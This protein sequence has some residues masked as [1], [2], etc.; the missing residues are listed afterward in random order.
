[1]ERAAIMQGDGW[2]LKIDHPAGRLS[3]GAVHHRK[4][5]YMEQQTDGRQG[6]ATPT[7]FFV[8]LTPSML[9]RP[10]SVCREN[11]LFDTEQMIRSFIGP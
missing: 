1:M 9:A 4:G 5:R 10:A 7:I 6:A 2:F 11:S 8:S 3:D